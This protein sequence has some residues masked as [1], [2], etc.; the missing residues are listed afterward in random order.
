MDISTLRLSNSIS[1]QGGLEYLLNFK[2]SQKQHP[3]VGTSFLPK[4]NG[5]L[6]AFVE[7]F[8]IKFSHKQN[9]Y[10][11]QLALF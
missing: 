2:N 4:S 5:K 3:E 6:L 9:R 7:G 1:F 10:V 8:I 11:S